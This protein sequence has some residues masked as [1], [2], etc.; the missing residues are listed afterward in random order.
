LN[1]LPPPMDP[2]VSMRVLFPVFPPFGGLPRSGLPQKR[3]APP[4]LLGGSTAFLGLPLRLLVPGIPGAL[5]LEGDLSWTLVV[6]LSGRLRFSFSPPTL[7]SFSA[8]SP[9]ASGLFAPRGEGPNLCFTPLHRHVTT[10]LTSLPRRFRFFSGQG[11]KCLRLPRALRVLVSSDLNFFF[12]RRG[13]FFS[14]PRRG[15][16]WARVLFAYP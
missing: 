7:L 2:P 6:E 12:S 15:T 8:V 14:I 1:C 9:V 16:G 3:A 10:F 5:S 11:G 13:P 4:P